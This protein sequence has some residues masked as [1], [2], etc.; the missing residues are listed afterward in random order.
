MRKASPTRLPFP[1]GGEVRSRKR[2]FCT[3]AV[4]LRTAVRHRG[5]PV[6][7]L[8]PASAQV[9]VSSEQG[10]TRTVI[11]LHA[12]AWMVTIQVARFP[13]ETALDRARARTDP[14]RPAVAPN[15]G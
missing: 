6:S 3:S 2:P 15:E 11:G 14:Q 9:A 5:A 12:H 8:P 10:L 4:T 7:L 13:G 1:A